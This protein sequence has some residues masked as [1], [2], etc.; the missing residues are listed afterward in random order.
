MFIPRSAIQVT[1]GI[2][3]A[4]PKTLSISAP[5]IPAMNE[6]RKNSWLSSPPLNSNIP[7]EIIVVTPVNCKVPTDAVNIIFHLSICIIQY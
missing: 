7:F 3:V 1:T 4:T 6:K 5:A 2:N